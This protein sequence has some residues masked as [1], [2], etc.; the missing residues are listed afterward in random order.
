M[1]AKGPA[2]VDRSGDARRRKI[3]RLGDPLQIIVA[4][5]FAHRSYGA[6]ANFEAPVQPLGRTGGVPT[7]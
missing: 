6:C 2:A 1:H 7:A 4:H 5:R 3:K